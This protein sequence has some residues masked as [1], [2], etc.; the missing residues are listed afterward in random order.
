MDACTWTYAC[1]YVSMYVCRSNRIIG[2]GALLNE[3]D[4]AALVDMCIDSEGQLR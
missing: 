3:M 2:Y 4:E 1:M